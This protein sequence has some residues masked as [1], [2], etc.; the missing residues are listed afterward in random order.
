MA[1]TAGMVKEL[2][3]KTNAGMLDCKKALEETAGNFEAA[4]D[5]LRMKGL[6]AAAKKADR[7]ASEGLVSA[8]KSA[9]GKVGVVVEVNSETDFVARNDKFKEFVSDMC[10]HVAAKAPVGSFEPATPIMDQPFSKNPAV[11]VAD[12]LKTA[13]ATIG[14]NLVVRRFAK[15]EASNSIVHTYV[16]GE[17]KIGVMLEVAADKAEAFANEAFKTFVNDVAL[18]IAALNPMAISNAE[19]PADTQAREREVLVGKA[20]EQG[21]K[22]EMIDKIV[23]G[24]MRKWLAENCLMDQA[25]VKNP[26]LTVGAYLKQIATSTGANITVKKFVRFELGAG[27]QKRQDNFAE[28]VAAQMKGR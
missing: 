4:V 24:Q 16:H 17:G 14:E 9:D 18:H 1:I 21:K 7:L 8:W 23:D 27:L 2:R 3:E 26:D 25:F 28:E 11:T 6:S 22:A 20:K 10:A 12:Q 5:W 13:V 15:F 19:I